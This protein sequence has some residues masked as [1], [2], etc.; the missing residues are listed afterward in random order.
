[1]LDELTPLQWAELQ[2]HLRQNPVGSRAEDWRFARLAIAMYLIHFSAA[3]E[4]PLSLSRLMSIMLPGEDL[5]EFLGEDEDEY[6]DPLV[7]A[8]QMEAWCAAQR[9]KWK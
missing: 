2:I 1:M 8:A 6:E 5:T 9:A 3:L 7:Q 4:E